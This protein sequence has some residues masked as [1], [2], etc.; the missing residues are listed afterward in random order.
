MFPVVLYVRSTQNSADRAQDRSGARASASPY[1]YRI[2]ALQRQDGYDEGGMTPG[3][4]IDEIIE[5]YKRDVDTTLI[6]ECLKRTVEERLLALQNFAA[7]IAELRAQT[8]G[9]K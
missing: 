2:A 7:A 1:T 5:L 4:S 3:N 9:R 6:D 8:A